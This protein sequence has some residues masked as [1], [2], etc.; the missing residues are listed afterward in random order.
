MHPELATKVRL[1]VAGK[2]GWNASEIDECA[3]QINSSWKEIEPTGVIHFLGPVTEEEKWYLLS[4]TSGLLFL[5]HE[6]GFG[7]PILEAMSVGA[8]VIASRG[9]A[10]EEVSGDQAILVDGSELDSI[11]M[12]IA[13]CILVPEGVQLLR[14]NGFR[15]ASQ[16]S[17]QKTAHETMSVFN[18][19][20]LKNI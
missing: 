18:L 9:G 14:E 17:W 11:A 4:R 8:P 20:L 10:I 6:E 16:F 19:R 5:S 1:I 15:R 2:S 7:L 13:Q 3:Q 12:A